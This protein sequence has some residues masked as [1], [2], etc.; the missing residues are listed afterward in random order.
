MFNAAL[1]RSWFGAGPWDGLAATWAHR[2]PP[3]SAPA[4]VGSLARQSV[5]AFD[6][7]VDICTRRPMRAFGGR[8]LHALADPSLVSPTALDALARQAGPALLTSQYLARRD[9][10]AILAWLSTRPMTDPKSATAH[11]NTLQRWLATL[12]AEPNA[13]VA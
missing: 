10:L 6:D 1:C 13:R 5:A 7:I 8:P 11:R 4:G 3:A 12:S 9:S 2:H